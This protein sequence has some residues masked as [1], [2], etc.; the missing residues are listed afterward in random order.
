MTST[1]LHKDKKVPPDE[2][3]ERDAPSC[4]NCG[5]RM[6][7]IRVETHLSDNGTQSVRYYECGRCRATRTLQTRSFRSA[8]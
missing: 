6:W 4:Q 1:F 2:T 3:E 7:I 5:Q 8:R